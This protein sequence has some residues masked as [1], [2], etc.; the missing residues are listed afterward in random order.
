MHIATD[1]VTEYCGHQLLERRRSVAVSYPHY[2]THECARDG[3][4][5]IL[6]YVFDTYAHL[7]VCIHQINFRAILRSSYILTDDFLVW[8]GRYVLYRVVVPLSCVDNGP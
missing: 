3:C 6:L 8:Q 1:C 2:V 5:C 7:L 4:K